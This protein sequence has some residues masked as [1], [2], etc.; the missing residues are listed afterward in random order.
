MLYTFLVVF[1]VIISVML[2]L[3]VLIQQGRGADMG[4]MF[5]GSSQTVFGAAGAGGFLGK[6]T[7]GFAAAF[8][9]VALVL[10]RMGDEGAGRARS[11]IPE[12]ETPAATTQK[13]DAPPA[14][15]PAVP[16]EPAPSAAAPGAEPS[17]APAATAPSAAAPTADSNVTPPP[18][19][20]A[21]AAAPA[22]AGE[23]PKTP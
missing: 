23:A 21:E 1:Q 11:L 5:G 16:T 13:S 2:I 20:A 6:L 8:F 3:V 18:A 22:P 10:A 12:D 4:A 7:Y 15:I 17:A 14:A 9:A 19:P